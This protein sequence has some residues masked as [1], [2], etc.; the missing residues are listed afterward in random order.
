MN[1][2][3]ILVFFFLF[4][5]SFGQ[6]RPEVK[7]LVKKI[8]DYGILDSEFTGYSGSQSEQYLNC[9]RL[10]SV[11]TEEDLLM[12]ICRSIIIHFFYHKDII[13]FDI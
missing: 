12:R 2:F 7:D 1:R 11:A 4:Q 3:F 5:V 6:V 8:S 13:S 10:D 9:K